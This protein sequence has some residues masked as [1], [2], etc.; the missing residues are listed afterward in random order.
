VRAGEW[1]ERVFPH[2]RPFFHPDAAIR[3]NSKTKVVRTTDVSQKFMVEQGKT[4]LIVA[5]IA[6]TKPKVA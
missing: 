5:R 3:R 1:G 2:P 4:Y 6:L